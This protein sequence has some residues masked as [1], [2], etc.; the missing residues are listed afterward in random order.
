MSH[1]KRISRNQ[2]CWKMTKC[3]FSYSHRRLRQGCIIRL[4]SSKRHFSCPSLLRRQSTLSGCVIRVVKHLKGH[5]L[6]VLRSAR[7]GSGSGRSVNKT[8]RLGA[9]ELLQKRS[10]VRI[11][12]YVLLILL[13][14]Q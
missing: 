4:N 5:W 8:R 2:A 10:Y 14:A 1:T 13:I 9:G 11:W 12:P 6:I 3:V 7:E